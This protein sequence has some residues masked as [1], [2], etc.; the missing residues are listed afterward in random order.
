MK[1]KAAW[2]ALAIVSLLWIGTLWYAFSQGRDF[3]QKDAE[4]VV[5][6]ERHIA[7]TK[8]Y[9]EANTHLTS[10]LARLRKELENQK[11][12]TVVTRTR[13]RER[14]VATTSPDCQEILED[15]SAHISNLEVELD[16]EQ[17][18]SQALAEVLMNTQGQVDHLEAAWQL[19]RERVG[20]YQKQ[21]KKQ[22]IKKV[23]IGISSAAAGIGVG[24]T[25]GALYK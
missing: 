15:A 23:V 14:K 24:F 2:I 13:W 16:L 11:T 8:Q 25:I 4:R 5:Q 21:Q 10:E 1:C 20:A 19:E 6:I 18:T 17:A 12:K 7:Q 9:R 22:K 3:S